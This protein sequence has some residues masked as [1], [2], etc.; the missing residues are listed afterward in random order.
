MVGWHHW[1][2]GHEFEQTPR[3][4]EG[5]GSLACCSPWVH[6]ESYMT[7]WLNKYI[8]FSLKCPEWCLLQWQKSSSCYED[9]MIYSKSLAILPFIEKSVDPCDRHI[10][11][12]DR[13]ICWCASPW[14]VAHQLL[15]SMEFSRQEYW[16]GLPFPPPGD[17]PD[18]RI[19]PTSPVSPTL[20]VDSL[21]TES[22]GK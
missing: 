1:L 4:T 2:T 15:L 9:C 17:L 13:H 18:P 5:Q 3:D 19:K 12:C 6:K 22:S 8:S 7:W 16:S 21:P 11:W 14:T 10:C 20:Q